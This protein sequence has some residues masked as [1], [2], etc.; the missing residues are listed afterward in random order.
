[1]TSVNTSARP[2]SAGLCVTQRD[3]DDMGDSVPTDQP[4]HNHCDCTDSHCTSH[5]VLPVVP[6]PITSPSAAE[7]AQRLRG[8]EEVLDA[9]EELRQPAVGV[10]GA[11]EEQGQKRPRLQSRKTDIDF[12][13]SFP[14]APGVKR[15]RLRV[16]CS[17]SPRVL[18]EQVFFLTLGLHT[19]LLSSS[20]CDGLLFRDSITTYSTRRFV[21]VFTETGAHGALD[22]RHHRCASGT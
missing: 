7:A 14:E 5:I 17:I 1:M 13:F 6:S 21:A 4:S 10:G 18:S 11:Q 2:L 15:C 19:V 20:T 16:H 12:V 22:R 3:K 9:P 8:D